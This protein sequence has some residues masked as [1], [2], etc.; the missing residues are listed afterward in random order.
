MFSANKSIRNGLTDSENDEN[1]ENENNFKRR[2]RRRINVIYSSSESETE[3]IQESNGTNCAITWT[4]NH[5]VPKIY[6]FDSKYSGITEEIRRSNATNRETLSII[7][8]LKRKEPESSVRS[9]Q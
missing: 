3:L 2:K 1:C 7:I 4:E 8:Y 5:F 9:L 6:R